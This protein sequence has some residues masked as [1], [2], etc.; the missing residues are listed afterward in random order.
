MDAKYN[1]V[2]DAA[3]DLAGDKEVKARVE[4][5]I[6]RSAMVNALID[7]RIQAGATQADIAKKMHCTQPRVS[8]IEGG[9]DETLRWMDIVGYA[10]ALRL[11]MHI[12]FDNDKLPRAQRIKSHV[13]QIHGLLEELANLAKG[14][15]DDD[16]LVS[17]IHEFYGEVL[18]NFMIKF[19]ENYKQL[20]LSENGG[21]LGDNIRLVIPPSRKEGACTCK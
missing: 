18:F 2:A 7:L 13:M 12:S 19:E 17:K 3:A 16:A 1:N 8:K 14:V 21:K 9:T 15:C 11:N 20:P 4:T 6:K 10:H 5:V